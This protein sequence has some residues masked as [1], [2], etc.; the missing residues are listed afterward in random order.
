MLV[1]HCVLVGVK[2]RD[3]ITPLP[4]LPP[5]LMNIFSLTQQKCTMFKA[6]LLPK[7]FMQR[8]KWQNRQT[9]LVPSLR[10]QLKASCPPRDARQGIER[11]KY[12]NPHIHSAHSLSPTRH[13]RI[14]P[15][16]T[17]Q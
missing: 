9:F 4:H 7:R 6:L 14:Q 12:P 11:E 1:W 13:H 16:D 17:V 3:T 5:E 8:S 15:E 10:R 2:D